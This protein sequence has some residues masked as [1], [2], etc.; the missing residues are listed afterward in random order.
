MSTK[1]EIEKCLK[2]RFA[3]DRLEVANE[4]GQHNVPANSETHFKVVMVSADFEG[5]SLLARHQSVYAALASFLSGGVHALSL[6]L[7]T[8]SEWIARAEQVSPSPPCRGGG[9][10]TPGN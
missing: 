10:V 5:K 6:H 3:L 8:P 1:E 9:S 4:S 2:S 7:F